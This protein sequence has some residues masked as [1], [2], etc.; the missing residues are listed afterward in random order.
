MVKYISCCLATRK[1]EKSITALSVHLFCSFY[2]AKISEL[3]QPDIHT[4]KKMQIQSKLSLILMMS[5]N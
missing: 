2:C 1:R 5:Q 4:Q 3:Y